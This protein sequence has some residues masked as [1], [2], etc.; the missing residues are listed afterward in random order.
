MNSAQVLGSKERKS[1]IP[2]IS[3]E[4]PPMRAGSHAAGSDWGSHTLSW[5]FFGDLVKVPLQ[6]TESSGVHIQFIFIGRPCCLADDVSI[7]HVDFDLTTSSGCYHV[8]VTVSLQG[9]G[10]YVIKRRTKCEANLKML[11]EFNW[12]VYMY[13]SSTEKSLWVP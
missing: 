13:T 11:G 8:P 9:D 12:I 2:V 4:T 6:V 1:T 5:I 7:C 3:A 10:K